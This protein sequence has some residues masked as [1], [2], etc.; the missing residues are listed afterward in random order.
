MGAGV[1]A[2]G[3]CTGPV[4]R[5]PC[6]GLRATGVM[7]GVWV[8]A[9]SLPCCP[10]PGRAAGARWPRA[11]GAGVGVCGVCGVCAVRVRG[12]WCRL[13]PVPLVPPSPVLRCG[14]VPAVC[15]VPAV[16]PSARVPCSAAGYP[17]FLSWLRRS[18]PFP[19]LALLPGMH[20]FPASAVVCVSVFFLAGWSFS[21]FGPCETMEG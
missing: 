1:R 20:L 7:G 5:V 6:G 16:L 3:S 10:P 21:L 2:W 18:L 19:L 11:L 12:A 13:S 4:A 8:Q 17:W 14:V 9:P 15:R